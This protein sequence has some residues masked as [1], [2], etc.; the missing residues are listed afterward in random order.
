[1]PDVVELFAGPGGLSEGLRAALGDLDVLAVENDADAVATARAAGHPRVKA[2]VAHYPMRHGRGCDGVAAAPPCQSFSMGGLRLREADPRGRLVH[3]PLRWALE[4]RPRWVVLEQVPEVLPIWRRH[5]RA[6]VDAGY[7]GWC[8]VVNAVDY[9]TPQDR[10]RAVLLARRDGRPVGP[11]VRHLARIS[12]AAALG[13]RPA[14][15][16]GLPR[17]ADPGRHAVEWNGQLYRERD[18]RRASQPSHTVTGKARSWQRWTRDAQGRPVVV[19]VE[20]AEVSVLQGF[21]ADYPWRGLRS[22][23]FQA[24]ANATPPPLAR[25]L[26]ARATR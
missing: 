15:Q 18:L 12:A 13:W 17:R 24:L 3:E 1:V 23:R 16:F 5:L 9:S 20:L 26:V 7:R 21:R 11:P 8:G 25:A 6:L 19:P 14:D 4:L 2:D 10:R 22:N